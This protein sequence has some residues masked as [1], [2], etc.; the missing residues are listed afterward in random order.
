MHLSPPL[1]FEPGPAP[2]VE[3]RGCEILDLWIMKVAC[4]ILPIV[5]TIIYIIANSV[6]SAEHDATNH[7]P[8]RAR[9]TKNLVDYDICFLVHAVAFLALSLVA[10]CIGAL[11]VTSILPTIF[12]GITVAYLSYKLVKDIQ[13]LNRELEAAG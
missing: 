8:L 1:Y 13:L 12:S 10:I 4:A 5:S 6:Y 7:I 11:A 3:E 9:A 2:V